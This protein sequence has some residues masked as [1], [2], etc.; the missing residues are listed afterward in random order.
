VVREQATVGE[1]LKALARF[2]HIHHSGMRLLIDSRKDVVTL[3]IDLRGALSRAPRQSTEMALGSLHRIIRSLA[4][5]DWR[6]LEAHLTH[7]P[8]RN[9]K[10]YRSFFGCPL[11]FNAENDALVISA[12][13][14]ER[15]IPSAH[16]LIANYLEK[17]VEAIDV[18]RR[19]WDERVI[20]VVRTLLNNG[21]CTADRVAVHFACTRRTIHRHLAECGTSFSEILDAERADLAL[22][23]IEDR[24]RPLASVAEMLGFSAQS[25]MARWFKGRFGRSISEWRGDAREQALAAIRRW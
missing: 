24:S 7:S 21:D 2:I 19:Q 5:E 22:R 3:A 23:L 6:P 9:R 25:A 13:D 16:P 10:Y 18:R 4:G 14:L 8:P 1:A 11:V 12:R 20:E 15:A 17:R